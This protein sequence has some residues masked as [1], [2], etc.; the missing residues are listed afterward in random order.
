MVSG[1]KTTMTATV[2]ATTIVIFEPFGMGPSSRV[3]GAATLFAE[4]LSGLT[5]AGP[6]AR[7]AVPGLLAQAAVVRPAVAVDVGFDLAAHDCGSQ[8]SRF[9]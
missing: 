7:L 8:P 6:V 1:R 3:P 2:H 4:A 9:M 5:L